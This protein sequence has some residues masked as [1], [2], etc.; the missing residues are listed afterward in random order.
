VAKAAV[1][2]SPNGLATGRFA[3]LTQSD[4]R[5]RF[6]RLSG[7]DYVVTA[8]LQKGPAEQVLQSVVARLEGE[9]TSVDIDVT[10]GPSRVQVELLHADAKLPS[11]GLLYLA[12]GSVRA[13]QLAGLEKELAA[14][15][16]GQTRLNMFSG[17]PLVRVA[18]VVPGLYTLCVVAVQV[19]RDDP[20]AV[21]ALRN[22]AG[23][24]PIHCEPFIVGDGSEQR[25]ILQL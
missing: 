6:E 7:R 12:T 23:E 24:L 9:T 3:V 13:T 16:A 20:A 2:A 10:F 1:V 15:G 19:V 17:E 5:Y 11:G 21:Q 22:R 14:R 25:A 8:A 18:D 4:G